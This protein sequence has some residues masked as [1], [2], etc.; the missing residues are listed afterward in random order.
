MILT[1]DDWADTQGAFL[2]EIV[3]LHISYKEYSVIVQ[4][5]KCFA[6]EWEYYDEVADA[7]NL[8]S[9]F[10]NWYKISLEIATKKRE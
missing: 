3:D 5:L 9:E 7:V 1:F 6:I 8:V 2:P 4:A 10:K